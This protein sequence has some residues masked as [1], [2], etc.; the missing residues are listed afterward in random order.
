MEPALPFAARCA[1]IA[2]QLA[3]EELGLLPGGHPETLVAL[4]THY[5]PQT[6][7]ESQIYT[8]LRNMCRDHTMVEALRSAQ[9]L[10]HGPAWANWFGH[11][12]AILHHAG[13]NWTHDDTV[14]MDDL[15]QIALLEL[16]R[17]LPSYRYA[18]RFSTWAYQVITHGVQRHLRDLAAKKRVGVIDR[19]TDPLELAVPISE[20]ELP[21]T[22]V[23][24]RALAS[25]V[26]TELTT[27]MGARNA[28]V[29]RLWAHNDLSAEMIGQQ[30]GL[31]SARI[32]AIIAQARRH[33]QQHPAVQGWYASNFA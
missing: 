10:N 12:R 17:S 4:A 1:S 31:S 7:S 21:E 18:S 5:L 32:H 16:T 26:E 24:G 15:A 13:L 23:T 25:L 6:S 3:E 27:A 8:A 30:V 22:Q 33:L 20:A 29:F 19:S 2:R 9:H 28:T 14:D 11:A